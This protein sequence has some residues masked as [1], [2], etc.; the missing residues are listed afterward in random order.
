MQVFL[1]NF[2]LNLAIDLRFSKKVWSSHFQSIKVGQGFHSKIFG[3]PNFPNTNITKSFVL[4]P[5]MQ[6]QSS[7]IFHDSTLPFTNTF[8]DDT[9]NPQMII[10]SYSYILCGL[11]LSLP[12]A[13]TLE[14]NSTFRSILLLVS[15]S[16]SMFDSNKSAR[17]RSKST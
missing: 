4:G 13:I 17:Y 8:S 15:I 6:N 10:W 1:R 3:S 9:C 5:I 2:C 7:F 16:F 14:I 11:A 12:S